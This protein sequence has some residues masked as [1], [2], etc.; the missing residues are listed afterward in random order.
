MI[1]SYNQNICLNKAFL[2][3]IW[4]NC[5]CGFCGFYLYKLCPSKTQVLGVL[6]G[7]SL[8]PVA[9]LACSL[10]DL[11]PFQFGSISTVVFNFHA[12]HNIWRPQW[13]GGGWRHHPVPMGLSLTSDLPH[14][15]GRCRWRAPW[16]NPRAPCL[17][18][19]PGRSGMTVVFQSSLGPSNL[20]RRQG[21]TLTSALV[22]GW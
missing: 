21:C 12:H 16:W 19:S 18:L 7:T 4:L 10:K 20:S 22:S 9:C 17:P 13:D 2:T 3:Y 14:R 1:L 8:L 11:F 15:W 5:P 6:W